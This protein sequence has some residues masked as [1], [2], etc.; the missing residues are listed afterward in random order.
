M[1]NDPGKE[2]RLFDFHDGSINLNE[3]CSF[4]DVVILTGITDRMLRDA[5][6]VAEAMEQ[7]ADF[8]GDTPLVAHNAAFDGRFL[9]AE[10]RRI[11]RSR[12]QV[13]AC[14][15]SASIDRA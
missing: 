5:P 1:L 2:R 15:L 7:L 14:S 4:G 3:R 13:M 11:G 8:I 10:L 9:D 12:K 6:P